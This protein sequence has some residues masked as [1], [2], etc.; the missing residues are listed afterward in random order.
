MPKKINPDENKKEDTSVIL[1]KS[2]IFILMKSH[3]FRTLQIQKGVGNPNLGKTSWVELL[4]IS[5]FEV[6]KPI[7][8]Q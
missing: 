8:H 4:E 7:Y 5:A 2:L 3:A 1:M 6:I